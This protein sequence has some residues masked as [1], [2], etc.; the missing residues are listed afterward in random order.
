MG[1]RLRWRGQSS[2]RDVRH[3][4]HR[5]GLRPGLARRRSPAVAR[6]HAVAELVRAQSAIELTAKR[7]LLSALRSRSS[8]DDH[9]ERSGSATLRVHAGRRRV[10]GRAQRARYGLASARAVRRHSDQLHDRAFGLLHFQSAAR[11]L[12]RTRSMRARRRCVRRSPFRVELTVKGPS[13]A[14]VPRPGPSD[15]HAGCCQSGLAAG[16]DA[17]G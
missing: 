16:S 7:T 3:R 12:I 8:G 2:A 1:P 14:A 6:L 10:D 15:G 4:S 13:D 17:Q 11:R 5:L 9:L